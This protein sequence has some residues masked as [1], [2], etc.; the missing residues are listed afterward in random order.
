MARYKPEIHPDPM[1]GDLVEDVTEWVAR[2][3][4]SA[5]LE[6]LLTALERRYW[7]DP[8]ITCPVIRWRIPDEL[9]ADIRERI[10]EIV[11]NQF[12]GRWGRG[13]V[14][15][16]SDGARFWTELPLAA[17]LVPVKGGW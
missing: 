4:G 13:A 17:E 10:T 12:N 3:S 16:R 9:L 14:V 8:V 7:V 15:V 2:A 1:P 11:H 6:T 5:D